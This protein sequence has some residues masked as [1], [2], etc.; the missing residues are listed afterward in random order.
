[1]LSPQAV[2][3]MIYEPYTI[4]LFYYF[5]K[6]LSA[7]SYHDYW[8]S[9]LKKCTDKVDFCQL[10]AV[11]ISECLTPY[12]IIKQCQMLGDEL[13]SHFPIYLHS[14][15]TM[16]HVQIYPTI[17]FLP[18]ITFTLRFYSNQPVYPPPL[19][20]SFMSM[21]SSTYRAS[22]IMVLM[23]S[24]IECTENTPH[25]V[26]CTECQHDSGFSITDACPKH[27]AP[28]NCLFMMLPMM[29]K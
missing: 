15:V 25:A 21:V 3:F 26:F 22:F 18:K 14:L 29:F 11:L 4:L 23:Y 12:K 16:I 9:W 13:G 17:V 2:S 5:I 10:Y 19:L 20:C 27:T 28:S 1:M 7:S 24:R 8:N 6:F